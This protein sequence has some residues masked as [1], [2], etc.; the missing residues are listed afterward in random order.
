M[1]GT[2]TSGNTKE[3]LFEIRFPL[4]STLVERL[5]GVFLPVLKPY[6]HPQCPQYSSKHMLDMMGLTCGICELA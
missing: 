6:D 3:K 5:Y 1:T 2:E 4:T